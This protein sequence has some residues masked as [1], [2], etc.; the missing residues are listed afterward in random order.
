MAGM[1]LSP[2]N[3]VEIRPATSLSPATSGSSPATSGLLA[4]GCSAMETSSEALPARPVLASNV[5]G[6]P[7]ARHRRPVARRKTMA[8]K[9]AARP[10]RKAAARGRAKPH[11]RLAAR[12]PHRKAAVLPVRVAQND[13]PTLR[14]LTFASPL[15]DDLAPAMQAFGLDTLPI[16]GLGNAPIE[17]AVAPQNTEFAQALTPSRGGQTGGG[18]FGFP[19]SPGFPGF[20]IAP[21]LGGGTVGT[22]GGDT[23]TGGGTGNGGN[24]GTGDG[25]PGGNAPSAAPEPSSWGMMILG[26]GMAGA[27]LRRRRRIARQA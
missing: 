16:T 24:G 5:V 10:V 25:T 23:G 14:K 12:R 1:A 4:T 9:P 13:R 15:C 20:G 7:R 21:P 26:F 3:A 17:D 6:R 27:G 19:F 2:A 11:A 8:H 22:P 18:G